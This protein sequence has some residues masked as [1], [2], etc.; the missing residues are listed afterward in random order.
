MSVL[1]SLRKCEEGDN[2]GIL[3]VAKKPKIEEGPFGDIKKIFE[4]SLTHPQRKDSLIVP[5]K[6]RKREPFCFGMVLC[7]M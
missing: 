4:E 3:S 6:N 5:Q 7:F 1:N 2:S